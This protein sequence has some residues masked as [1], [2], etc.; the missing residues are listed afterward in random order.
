MSTKVEQKVS[1]IQKLDTTSPTQIVNLPEVADRF[2]K[3]YVTFNGKSGEKYYEAEKFHFAK[4]LQ[5][6]AK[7]AECSKLSLYGCFLDVAVNGLSFDPTMKHVY[8]VP[9]NVKKGDNNWEKRAQLQISGQGELLLRMQQGQIKYADNPVLVYEGDIFKTG[10]RNGQL[11]VDH[12][13]TI[14][15]KSDTIIACYLRITRNDDSADYKVLTMPEIEKLRKFSKDPNSKAWTDGLPGMVQAKTI[16]HAFKNYPK[17]RILEKSKF[18]ALA[19]DTVDEDAEVV[20]E[21]IYGLDEEA[22]QIQQPATQ[23]ATTA[24]PVDDNSFVE[25]KPAAPTKGRSFDD[26]NF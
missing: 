11:F 8:L 17:L 3:L 24:S 13:A 9:Y 19:S 20:H 21:D 12:E 4:L 1:I 10:T 26:D 6:N 7:L 15:R 23:S 5:E 18:T 14:P 25:E 2:K 16:K 22:K